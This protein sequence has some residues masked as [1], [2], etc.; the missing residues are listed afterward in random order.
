MKRGPWHEVE[1]EL[2]VALYP[3]HATAKLAACFDRS[4]RSVYFK[5]YQLGLKKS[6]TFLATPEAGR[7]QPGSRIGETGRFKPG[8]TPWNKGRKGVSYEGAKA[9]QFQL[10]SN[11]HNWVPIGTDRP[12]DGYLCRKMTDTGYPRRDWVPLHVLLWREHRGP[13]PAGHV[14]VFRD[15]NT[16]HIDLDNLECISR[17]ELMRRNTV[18]NLPAPL[19][20]VIR[21]KGALKRVIRNKEKQHEQ[22]HD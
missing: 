7:I 18:N 14:V 13:V 5:A 2:L 9:T 16:R 6:A 1:I 17:T 12:R 3:D 11:P 4:E 8:F 10:G 22:Q 21:L 20:Q 15:R 19:K